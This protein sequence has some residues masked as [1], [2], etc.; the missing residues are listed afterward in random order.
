MTPT[1]S[2]RVF[3]CLKDM[4]PSLAYYSHAQGWLESAHYTS[5]L[6]TRSNNFWGIKWTRR[7]QY[8]STVLK[9]AEY[10]DGKR[11]TISAG[12]VDFPQIEDGCLYYLNTLQRFYPRAYDAGSIQQFAMG[13]VPRWAT[14]PRYAKKVISVHNHL[15]G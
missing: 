1:L 9:T 13:L 14:D 11:V 5:K 3:E 8:P 10:L 4:R 7:S 6:A 15:F 2:S 12:F